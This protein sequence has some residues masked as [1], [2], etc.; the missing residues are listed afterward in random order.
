MKHKKQPNI[1]KHLE[2]EK[3]K[4]AWGYQGKETE[5][6]DADKEGHSPVTRARELMSIASN[7][8]RSGTQGTAP[9]VEAF[10]LTHKVQFHTAKLFGWS[11]MIKFPQLRFIQL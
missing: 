11:W 10:M 1:I 8:Q 9:N 2:D 7:L 5:E 3:Q 6:A 4:I